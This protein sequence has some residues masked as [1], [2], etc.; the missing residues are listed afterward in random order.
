MF[1]LANQDNTLEPFCELL[2]IHFLVLRTK[3]TMNGDN[4]NDNAGSNGINDVFIV[5]KINCLLF[6]YD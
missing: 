6:M 2:A 3:L 4:H 1:Y 5:D